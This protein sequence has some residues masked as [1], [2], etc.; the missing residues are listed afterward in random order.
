MVTTSIS[1]LSLVGMTHTNTLNAGDTF[2]ITDS[3]GRSIT[4]TVGQA[5]GMA[6]T[7][8]AGSMIY[9]LND[10]RSAGTLSIPN[11]QIFAVNNTSGA[12]DVS[13]L[14]FTLGIAVTNNGETKSFSEAGNTVSLDLTNG[15]AN[16][17]VTAGSL[18]PASQTIGGLLFTASFQQGL[19]GGFNS[20]NNGGVSAV[21]S[22]VPEPSTF[23]L[24]GVGGLLIVAPR[25]RHVVRRIGARG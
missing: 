17:L 1:S 19:S 23:A 20:I 8:A 4:I 10:M 16:Y 18:T 12:T 14:S 2:G 11:E 6:I 21:I 7:D 13:T 15:N 24:L 25:L 9:L 22:A 3:S 5:G